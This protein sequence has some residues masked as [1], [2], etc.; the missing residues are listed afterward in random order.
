MPAKKSPSGRTGRASRP[1]AEA[2]AR[3]PR[4][5]PEHAPRHAEVD[6]DVVRLLDQ[7]G[8]LREGAK[9]TLATDRLLRVHDTM[10]LV[11]ALDER[12]IT[13]QRQGR[14]GFYGACTGEEAAV[15]GSAAGLRDTDWIVPALRQNSAM[16]FRGFPLSA[17]VSQVLGNSGDVMKARQ[18]PSHHASPS[19]RQV[20]WS[21]C[22]ANQ[23]LQAVGIARAMRTRGTG[24]VVAGF[25]GDGGTSEGDFH[26]AMNLAALWKLPMVIVVQNNQWAISVP[27]SRQTLVTR[28][29]DKARAYGMPGLRV[30]GNDLFAVHESMA[31]A[32]ERARSGGGPTLLELYTYRVGA[33]STSDDPSRYRDES[34]TEH[35]RTLDPLARLEAHLA[36]AGLRG[37]AEVEALKA[38]SVAEVDRAVKEAEAMPPVEPGTL[39][40]DVCATIPPALASQWA[41]WGQLPHPHRD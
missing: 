13:L 7:D 6:E 41:E 27:L 9:V 4:Q 24:D 18:M 2:P 15:L 23:L 5:A 34:I 21:S 3:A 17:Y 22:I 10:R 20:S 31:A 40:E 12:M 16:L 36:Q 11:R 25:C 32:A 35:W 8:I 19:V 28:I 33:H 14:A 29:A 37:A 1:P 39:V 30:D 26:V 38:R